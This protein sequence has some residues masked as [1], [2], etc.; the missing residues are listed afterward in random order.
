MKLKLNGIDENI[1]TVADT[2]LVAMLHET[3]NSMLVINLVKQ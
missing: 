1:E 3:I 2:Q